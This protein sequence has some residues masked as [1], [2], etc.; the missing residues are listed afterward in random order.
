MSRTDD[1]IDVAFRVFNEIGIVSQLA[2]TAF[3]RIMPAGMTLA[4]FTVLNHFARLGGERR[5]TD[6]ARAFQVT[7]ATMTST[8][9]KL[10]AKALVAV[11]SDARD[12]RGRLVSLTDAGRAMHAD[13]IARLHPM[14]REL[15]GA[16]GPEPFKAALDPLTRLRETL[17]AMREGGN[18]GR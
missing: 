7:K 3:E 18:P 17:D 10:D 15:V 11:T 8:L 9:Q 12:G 2:A 13:C 4:Q 6:L 5:P 1:T 14:L 16:I